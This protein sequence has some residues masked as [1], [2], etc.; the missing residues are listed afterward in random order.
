MGTERRIDLSLALPQS[1]AQPSLGDSSR[2][3]EGAA[4]ASDGDV[5]RFQAALA[6]AQAPADAKAMAEGAAPKI[7]AP[8]A[9]PGWGGAM[10]E[11]AQRG[12][13]SLA[14]EPLLE[15]LMV[16][17]RLGGGRQVRMELKDEVLPG[18]SVLIQEAG[19]RL[20][21]TFVCRLE[22]PRERLTRLAPEQ[23]RALAERLG[24]EVLLQVCTPDDEDP[25][26]FEVL[27]QP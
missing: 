23:A 12:E 17:D 21:V 3:G 26:L 11:L 19:G 14:L 8:F 15:R 20:Q 27:A 9:L 13:A 22:P 5:R 16:E 18:V 1:S 25:C 2:H 7:G 10:P 24:R 6:D 4:T